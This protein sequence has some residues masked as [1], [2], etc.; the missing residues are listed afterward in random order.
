MYTLHFVSI[1][2]LLTTA[3]CT[4]M[5][6]APQSKAAVLNW[7]SDEGITRLAESKHKVDFFKLA[8]HFEG[9]TN[10][11]FLRPH[12]SRHCSQCHARAPR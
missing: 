7:S 11:D 2:L 9:Q 12:V 5:S 6:S 10:K 1:A 3:G 8:N 4:T